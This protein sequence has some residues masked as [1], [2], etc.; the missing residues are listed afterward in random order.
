MTIA[1]EKKAGIKR[2][3][4]FLKANKLRET[5]ERLAIVNCIYAYNTRFSAEQIYSALQE[6][7]HV[8]LST[9]YNTLDLMEQSHLI[10]KHQID[11][12][13]S[14]ERIS[15]DVVHYHLVCTKCGVI[16]EFTDL[17]IKNAIKKKVFGTF[18]PCYHTLYLYGICKYCATGKKRR[19]K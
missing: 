16:K 6:T 19:K 7:F 5:A 12:H 15:A 8:S 1:E 10:V 13:L 14:Y 3:S 9:V 18:T 17:K 11:K 2:F 4:E